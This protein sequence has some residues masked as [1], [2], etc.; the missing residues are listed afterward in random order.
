M[1]QHE[2]VE[3]M[4]HHYCTQVS[5][6]LRRAEKERSDVAF[7]AGLTSNSFATVH[8]DENATLSA[9][10]RPPRIRITSWMVISP[11]PVVIVINDTL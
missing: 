9:E 5:F 10:E 4:L 11:I 1:Q 6:I 3:A 7:V 8:T 2:I